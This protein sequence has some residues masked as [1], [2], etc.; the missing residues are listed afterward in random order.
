MTAAG[1]SSTI[2]L[3][4]VPG[5]FRSF[6]ATQIAL[7][8]IGK[9]GAES[10]R[11]RAAPLTAAARIGATELKH[12]HP[13]GDLA[14][15]DRALLIASASSHARDRCASLMTLTCGAEIRTAP[16]SLT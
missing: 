3:H 4:G 2:V 7:T 14:Y 9:L 16:V 15:R 1:F 10:E 13:A 12:R 8:A 5:V 6:R 11:M